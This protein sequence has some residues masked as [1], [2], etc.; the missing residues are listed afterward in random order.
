[1]TSAA[2]KKFFNNETAAI[3]VD[4]V[5]LCAAATA[6]AI[7]TVDELRGGT[8]ALTSNMEEQLRTQQL[9]DAFVK[10][11]SNHFDPVYD[12]NLITEDQASQLWDQSN[13][14]TNAELLAQLG[15]YINKITDDAMLIEDWPEAYALASVAHQR[16]IVDDSVFTDYFN[17]N[18]GIPAQEEGLSDYALG[19]SDEDP[20]AQPTTVASND[21]DDDGSDSTGSSGSGFPGGGFP[22]GMPG[23]MPGGFPGG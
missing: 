5:V 3:S 6:M 12:A 21:D 18:P 2:V 16:N 14:M 17:E 10:F 1:M 8:D 13:D 22:G 20:N 4:Y 7:W 19:L 9:S 11:S 15:E 23:G